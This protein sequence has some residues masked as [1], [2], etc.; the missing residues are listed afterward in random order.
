[1]K[2]LGCSG[3]V[4]A[5]ILMF[6][7]G[8]ISQ[9]PISY[10]TPGDPVALVEFVLKKQQPMEPRLAMLRVDGRWAPQFKARGY[11]GHAFAFELPPGRHVLDARIAGSKSRAR[12]GDTTFLGNQPLT[13]E[14]EACA[15]H[16][17]RLCA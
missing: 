15:G 14:L 17:Y 1:M 11:D 5:A 10:V 3:F 12:E 2:N 8:C 13:I 16:N 6:C 9:R 4:L 7:N